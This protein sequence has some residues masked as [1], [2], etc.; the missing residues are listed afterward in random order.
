MLKRE[1]RLPRGVIFYNSKFYS[2]PIFNL[3]IKEN[4]L[5]LNRFGI[6]V[7]KKIDKRATFRNK[8]K[9]ILRS[10]LVDLNKDMM[11]GYDILFIVKRGII[12]KT[13]YEDSFQIKETLEEAKLIK[14]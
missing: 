2:T 7:G 12:G 3:K 14:K 5:A 1:N 4:G 9:R 8:I 11:K 6:I 10:A 13:N